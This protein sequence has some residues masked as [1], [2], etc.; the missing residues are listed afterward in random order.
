[1]EEHLLSSEQVLDAKEPYEA[2]DLLES[3][4]SELVLVTDTCRGRQ[5][6][7]PL[8][9]EDLLECDNDPGTPYADDVLL[10]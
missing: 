5:E 7:D 9:L 2:D 10:D 1:M 3:N 6:D 8:V 4:I